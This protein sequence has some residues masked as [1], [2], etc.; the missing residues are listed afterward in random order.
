MASNESTE[1]GLLHDKLKEALEKATRVLSNLHRVHSYLEIIK[2]VSPSTRAPSNEVVK[3][4]LEQMRIIRTDTAGLL[5]TV[6]L[7]EIGLQSLQD[8]NKQGTSGDLS[9]LMPV[10]LSATGVAPPVTINGNQGEADVMVGLTEEELNYTPPATDG[11]PPPLKKMY[12]L[13]FIACP[14][15]RPPHPGG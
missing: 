3:N 6:Y 9:T 8:F 12:V 15:P 13:C 14:V 7:T 10:V 4:A 11:M 5:Q 2:T 1:S